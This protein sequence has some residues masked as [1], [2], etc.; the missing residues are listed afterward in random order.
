MPETLLV[1]GV[2]PRVSMKAPLLAVA[3]LT[4]HCKSLLDTGTGAGAEIWHFFAVARMPD[5]V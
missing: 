2:V 1:G 4:K 3:N 5:T